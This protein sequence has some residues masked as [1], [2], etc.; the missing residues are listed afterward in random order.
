MATDLPGG[1][2][3]A[4]ER[5][6]ESGRLFARFEGQL[7]YLTKGPLITGNAPWFDDLVAMLD[8]GTG[9]SPCQDIR[10]EPFEMRD[11]WCSEILSALRPPGRLLIEITLPAQHD[12]GAQRAVAHLSDAR[13]AL[14]D[15]RYAEVARVGYRALDEI[16]KLTG[17]VTERYGAYATARIND[18]I[19]KARS[20]CNPERHGSAPHHDGLEF[21]RPLA[22]HVLAVATSLVGIVL[23]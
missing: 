2:L 21:D 4:I 3:D 10:S 6:R 20:L 23:R 7:Y 13:R 16:S 1:A 22:E 18:Q 19:D 5:F 14:D 15:G 9:R 8:G 11:R 17:R 12:D